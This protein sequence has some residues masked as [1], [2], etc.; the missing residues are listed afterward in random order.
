MPEE[1]IDQCPPDPENETPGAPV[2]RPAPLSR[3]DKADVGCLIF[4]GIGFVGVFLLPA[5][6]LLG[7]APVIVPLITCFLMVLATPFINPL[8]RR[9]VSAK[10]WGR[11]ITFSFL[12]GTIVVLWLWLYRMGDRMPTDDGEWSWFCSPDRDPVA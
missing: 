7:G 2:S 3:V 5:A 9:S 10:W 1:P 11:V 12:A 6:F 4:L 8:E